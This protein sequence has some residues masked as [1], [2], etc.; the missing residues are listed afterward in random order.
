MQI[1]LTIIGPVFAILGVLVGGAI[2]SR[3]QRR[4]QEIVYLTAVERER[5]DA[6]VQFL[7]AVR[8]YRRFLMYSAPTIEEVP[9]S[10]A[11]KGTVIVSGGT[12]Y[13]ANLD[14]AFSRLLI[15]VRSDVI[16]AEANVMNTLLNNFVRLCARHGKGMVP[17]EHV[18]EFRAAER[19]FASL[20]R[21]ERDCSSPLV[22]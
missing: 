11:S 4:N 7:T 12:E 22:R 21:A 10:E 6:C 15:I 13:Y 2:T 20:V 9:P 17:N 8:Q 3:T 16:I 19:S 14:E 18:R 5:Q 1:S